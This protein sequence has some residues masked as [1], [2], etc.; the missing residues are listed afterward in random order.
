VTLAD[1]IFVAT[2]APTRI[3]RLIDLSRNYDQPAAI[4]PFDDLFWFFAA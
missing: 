4:N 3:L 1:D 2:L